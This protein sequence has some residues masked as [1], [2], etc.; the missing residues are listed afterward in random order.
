M[1]KFDLLEQISHPYFIRI[2]RTFAILI[3]KFEYIDGNQ[4]IERGNTL[5]IGKA[6]RKDLMSKIER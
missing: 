1:K 6:Y 5:P 4:I 2:H 3:D